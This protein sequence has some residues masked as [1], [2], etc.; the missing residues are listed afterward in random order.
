MSKIVEQHSDKEF[1]L[2][3][4][5][6]HFREALPFVKGLEGRTFHN[7]GKFWTVPISPQ[8][9]QKLK[10]HRWAFKD[11]AHDLAYGPDP[12]KDKPEDLTIREIPVAEI[13][14]TKLNKKLRPYQVLAVKQVCGLNGRA[15]ISFPPG[16]GKTAVAASYFRVRLED[17][18]VLVICPAFLKIHW[19]REMMEWGGLGS[20]ICRGRKPHRPSVKKPVWI[21]NYDLLQYWQT[22]LI[23]Q[24][25]K[26]III[27]ECQMVS[28][29][30]TARTDSLLQIAKHVPHIIAVSGTPIKNRP[31]EFFTILHLLYPEQ[32][33]NRYKF[34]HRYCLPGN[35]P[36]L[37]GNYTTKPISKV[38]IGDRIIGW[39]KENVQNK[40]CCTTVKDVIKKRASLIK[41]SLSNG[42]SIVCTPDHKWF[43]GLSISADRS[44]EYSMPSAGEIAK[45][46]FCKHASR[47]VRIFPLQTIPYADSNE[48]KIGYVFGFL[49]GDGWFSEI[50]KT[51]YNIFR[52]IFVS[53]NKKYAIGAAC[54]DK[55]PLFY[56][57]EIMDLLH[58]PSHIGRR[59]DGLHSISMCNA[60]MCSFLQKG[61]PRTKEGYAGFLGGI[62]D[63][64]GS[65]AVITQYEA[66]N[67]KVCRIIEEAFAFLEIPYNKRKDTYSI[68]GGRK[69]LIR[70]W[71]ITAPKVQR[72]LVAF[73]KKYA[74]QAMTDKA[75]VTKITPLPGKHIVYTLTTNT[76]NYIAY[77]YGSKNCDPQYGYNGLEF[78]GATHVEELHAKISGFMIR[79]EK[80]EL[81]PELPPKKRYVIPMELSQPEA[82]K[83]AEAEI[84]LLIKQNKR[85]EAHDAL[86]ELSNTAF[87]LKKD[88]VLAWIDDWLEKN[89]DESLVIVVYHHAV[90]DF[91]RDY[92][93]DAIIVDG[94]RPAEKRQYLVD[95]FQAGE[96]RILIGQIL[97]AGIG[98]T[99]TKA[100]TMVVAEVCYV[101]GD[102]EQM[103]DREQR[104]GQLADEVSIYYLVGEGTIEDAM[105]NSV[106]RKTNSLSQILDGKGA[107]FFGEER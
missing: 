93:E 69:G 68:L 8:I 33:P 13:D 88:S 75:Y 96:S 11:S 14:E 98:F 38:K 77:G 90:I 83:Q 87:P 25:F 19:K 1:R 28:N 29:H 36:I 17:F 53:E 43:N 104:M 89:P 31:R 16:C 9:I 76:G 21:I 49:M 95:A 61:F 101:P 10:Q 39:Q 51:R 4:N 65:G 54:K 100:S 37:M 60:K 44:R 23:F 79:K 102:L 27:D 30:E 50:K 41:V 2:I 48:Y 103:E 63:A 71:D 64:E 107:S 34:Y 73:L 20:H 94:R 99:M 12:D 70:F 62:Y 40:L 5:G 15:I 92:Y 66:V 24:K 47:L 97:A 58:I 82:Y 78:K 80:W 84:E 56:I 86:M 59:G 3:F 74:G 85:K 6:P 52:D 67:S 35:A 81:L 46:G 106:E 57:K 45:K 105:L 32:F 91:L 72:K 18:P 26:T 55:A 42:D 22:E 7:E